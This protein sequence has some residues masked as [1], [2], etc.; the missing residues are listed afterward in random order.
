MMVGT[1]PRASFYLFVTEDV[2]SEFPIEEHNWAAGAERAD[3]LGVDVISSSLGYSKFTD[4]IFNYTYEDMNGKTAISSRAATAAARTGMIVCSSAG[5]EGTHPWHFITAPAD[6]D[7]ILTVGATDSLGLITAFSSQGPTSDGRLKPNVVAQGIRAWVIDP[8]P[9]DNTTFPGSGTSFSNPIVA[10]LTACL[11]QAHPE[12]NNQ[13]IIH[14]IEASA[15]L[16][17]NPNDSMGYGIPDFRVANLLLSENAPENSVPAIPFVYPNPFG[18]DINIVYFQPA[19]QKVSVVITDMLGRVDDAY[20]CT[21]QPGASG[22]AYLPT[23]YFRNAANGAYFVKVQFPDHT[24]V[25]R[26]VKTQ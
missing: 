24:D 19:A 16:F 26:V 5:N 14:A 1:A 10:G 11:W 25:L 17:K 23:S 7:S 3:S 15:T 22:Y 9:E 8:S 18:A 4:S 2:F 6:A 12:K 13:E 21:L 20:D